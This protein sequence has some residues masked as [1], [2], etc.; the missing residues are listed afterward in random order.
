MARRSEILARLL[1]LG[2]L[3]SV[4]KIGSHTT[5]TRN[6]ALA[7]LARNFSAAEAPR[8]QVAHVGDS[9]RTIR[10]WSAAESNAL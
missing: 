9:K 7:W 10:G 3:K 5:K 1:P 4:G 6:F 2:E 8:R